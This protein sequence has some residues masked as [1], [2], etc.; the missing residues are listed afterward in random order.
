[1]HYS[2]STRKHVHT[3]AC[4]QFSITTIASKPLFLRFCTCSVHYVYDI[5]KNKMTLF[6]ASK[7]E[8]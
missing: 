6:T 3:G 8:I 2:I 4:L 7:E 5:N 1:M